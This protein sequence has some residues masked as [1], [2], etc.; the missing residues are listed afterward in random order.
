MKENADRTWQPLWLVW[1][2]ARQEENGS[3]LLQ[4]IGD[5]T[6][7]E[8]ADVVLLL[9]ASGR[10]MVA[11]Q[12]D[13]DWKL[14]DVPGWCQGSLILRD[15]SGDGVLDIVRD[16]CGDSGRRAAGWQGVGFDWVE[17]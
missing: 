3:P 12:A 14:Y 7:D 4:A 11:S 2:L 13:D 5:V 6:G 10:L 17:N 8:V 15:V 16:G 1:P 9:P